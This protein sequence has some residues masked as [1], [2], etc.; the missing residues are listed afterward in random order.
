MQMRRLLRQGLR[1]AGYEVTV[2][3]TGE[4]ALESFGRQPVDL[5]ILDLAMPG[6]GGLETCRRLR[7]VSSVPIVVLSVHD[8]EADKIAA[9][10]LGAD[11]YLT[12]PFALGELLARI[13]AALRRVH[14][15]PRTEPVLITGPLSINLANHLVERDGKRIHLTP[16]EFN[17]LAYLV[18]H[19]DRVVTHDLLLQAIWPDRFG[20][21]PHYLHVYVSQLR[22]KLEPNPAEPRFIL[23][24]LGIGYRFRT[25]D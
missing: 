8:S 20:P 10:D 2:A 25:A 15:P 7:A 16:T 1:G 6:I 5:V 18:T 9:L 19:A 11:D 3:A 4:E 24:E 17:I 22:R 21:E 14:T 13:R 23:T 12:K